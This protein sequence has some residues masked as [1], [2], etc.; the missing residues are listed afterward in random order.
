MLTERQLLILQTIIENFVETAHPI[1]SRALSKDASINLSA[2]TI[3]NVMADLE[4]MELLEKTHSSSGRIPSE[5]GYRYYVDHVITPSMK[6]NELNI[7]RNKL[8]HNM[9]ELEHVV[10]LSAEVLS[11]LTNYTAVILGQSEVEARLK[12]I[13]MIRLNESKAIAILVTNTGHVEH[14]SFHIPA[15]ISMSDF[16]KLINI[17]ND[18]LINVPIAQ[19]GYKLQTEIYD[20]MRSQLEE[21]EILYQY[22][23]SI[24]AYQD[25]SKLYVGGQSNMLI[26]PEFQDIN[27]IYDFYTLLE[28]EEQMIQLLSGHLGGLTVTIGNENEMDAIKQFSLITTP[29][30]ISG[31]QMGTI[32]LLGPTRMQYRKVLSLL[33]GL[34]NEITAIYDE[35]TNRNNLNE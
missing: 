19:L 8:N 3:R 16:E 23:Q 21:Y 24:L 14:K 6:E 7:L 32:A 18:R 22:M 15:S 33:Q 26:Q 31:N 34:A 5:K 28:N 2:A 35:N 9:L 25:T 12:Q 27:K 13:Q 4:D 1:G 29:Y 11:E 10:Q 20:I 17:L 30:K